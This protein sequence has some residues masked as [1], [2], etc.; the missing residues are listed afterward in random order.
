VWLSL[1]LGFT[2]VD[3]DARLRRDVDLDGDGLPVDPMSVALRTAASTATSF[4]WSLA[5]GRAALLKDARL[6]PARDTRT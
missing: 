1:R 6:A 2:D 3:G 4:D 5:A